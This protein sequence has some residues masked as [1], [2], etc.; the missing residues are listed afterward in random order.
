M[1]RD[2]NALVGQVRRGKMKKTAEKEKEYQPP[3][4]EEISRTAPI[5][6]LREQTKSQSNFLSYAVGIL[7]ALI[8]IWVYL[9]IRPL[10]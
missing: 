8:I 7:A 2:H 4:D 3:G 5:P 9:Q 10:W 6:P 1:K